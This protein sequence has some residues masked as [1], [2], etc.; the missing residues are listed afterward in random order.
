[1][2]VF[3]ISFCGIP[4]T[5]LIPLTLWNAFFPLLIENG[6]LA[7]ILYRETNE[8]RKSTMTKLLKTI[9]IVDKNEKFHAKA[10]ERYLHVHFI[11]TGHSWEGWVP[12]E[13]RRTNLHVDV[14]NE[15]ELADYLN[16]I[17]E[18]LNPQHYKEWRLAQ[19]E[20]WRLEKPNASVTKGFFDPLADAQGEWVCARCQLPHNTNPQRRIQDIKDFG[21]TLATDTNRF[22][23]HCGKKTTHL[24]LLPI[25]RADSSGNGYET[26]TPAM[27]KRI[28]RVLGAWDVYEAANSN[29]CLPDH[30]FPEIRW[31]DETKADNPDTMSNEEIASKFQLMT[32]QRNEQKREVCRN[33]FQTGK[34]GTIFGIDFFYAGTADWD[35]TIPPKGKEAEQGCIGC[36]WYDIALWRKKLI[37]KLQERE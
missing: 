12:T 35:R 8:V 33:C 9:V 24:L 11:Y 13:Y 37:E 10:S 31:D 36:P 19:E 28:I 22:C 29:H 21:Y 1:M 7:I 23:K 4:R 34:R 3:P 30:K 16:Q 15:D 26:W 2:D 6:F 5:V 25:P 27:R 14:N 32:N 20:F 17:Y 18:Q